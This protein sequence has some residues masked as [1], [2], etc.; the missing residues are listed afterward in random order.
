MYGYYEDFRYL[1]NTLYLPEYD[2][3]LIIALLS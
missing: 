2:D 3:D 1:T